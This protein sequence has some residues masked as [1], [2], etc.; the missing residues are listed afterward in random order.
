MKLE[1]YKTVKEKVKVATV[2]TVY[3]IETSIGVVI[4]WSSILIVATVLT[5]YGIETPW[6]HRF[7]VRIE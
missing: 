2:L 4:N 5:V 1:H 3:G 7:V 6:R